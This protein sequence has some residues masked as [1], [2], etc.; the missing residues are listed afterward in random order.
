V[1]RSP[2]PASTGAARD[3]LAA[4]ACAT[5]CTATGPRAVVEPSVGDSPD[6]VSEGHRLGK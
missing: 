4:G 5:S 6:H 3:M 2:A 1:K